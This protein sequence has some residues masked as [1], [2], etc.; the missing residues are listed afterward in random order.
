MN[1]GRRIRDIVSSGHLS[2]V[3]KAIESNISLVEQH[4][5]FIQTTLERTETN[6]VLYNLLY[7]TKLYLHCLDSSLKGPTEQIGFVTRSLFEL[8]LITRY[9]LMSEDNLKRFVAESA[10]DRIKILEGILELREDSSE[11]AINKLET[12][13]ARIN[14]ITAKHNRDPK[15]PNFIGDMARTVGLEQEYNALYKLFSKYV[16]P[17]SYTINAATKEIHS[18]EVRNIFFIFAQLYAGDILQQ[19]EEVTKK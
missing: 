3:S 11:E 6:L 5:E 19:I 8:N 16:H 4:A 9:V 15:K 10:F 12:E 13:I 17:S 2:E 7:K 14:A 18:D 1:K